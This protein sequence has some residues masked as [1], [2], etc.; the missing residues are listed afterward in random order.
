MDQ[1]VDDESVLLSFIDFS[2]ITILHSQI[3]FQSNIKTI[4]HWVKYQL[5]GV[6]TVHQ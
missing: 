3:I 2:H 4:L 5:F 1:K 6:I